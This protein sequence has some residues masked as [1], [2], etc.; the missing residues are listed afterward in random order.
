MRGGIKDAV[1][2][3]E[4]DSRNY[5]INRGLE[6]GL[7]LQDLRSNLLNQKVEL[8]IVKHWTPLDWNQRL[9]TIAEIKSGDKIYFSRL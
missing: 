7:N 5:Y 1:F 8:K 6:N 9:G 2:N 3:L 4:G